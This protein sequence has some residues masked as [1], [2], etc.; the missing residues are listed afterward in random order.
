MY[1]PITIIKFFFNIFIYKVELPQSWGLHVRFQLWKSSSLALT[2]VHLIKRSVSFVFHRIP[3]GLASYFVC[4]FYFI[5]A[6]ID[7]KRNMMCLKRRFSYFIVSRSLFSA[8]RNSKVSIDSL[9]H[10]SICAVENLEFGAIYSSFSYWS[11]LETNRWRFHY[12]KV[13][14]P[15]I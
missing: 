1:F 12:N 4:L 2:R 15:T 13:S 14:I 7:I 8:L 3:L 11:N 6:H 5:K 9:I 10:Q